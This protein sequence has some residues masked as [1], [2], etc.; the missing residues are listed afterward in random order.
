MLVGVD[1]AGLADGLQVKSKES[2]QV[3]GLSSLVA[4]L[5]F[6]RRKPGGEAE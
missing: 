1:L 6:N 2:K 5:P 4:A 3:P